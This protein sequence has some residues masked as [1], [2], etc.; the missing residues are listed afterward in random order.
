VLKALIDPAPIIVGFRLGALVS[1]LS[2]YSPI[3][4]SYPVSRSGATRAGDM[5]AFR[6]GETEEGDREMVIPLD[7]PSRGGARLAARERNPPLS[8]LAARMVPNRVGTSPSLGPVAVIASGFD[9]ETIPLFGLTSLPMTQ[10]VPRELPLVSE[11]PLSLM[12]KAGG[13]PSMLVAGR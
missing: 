4:S 1:P 7:G 8:A 9:V 13:G 10:G 3:M 6:L 12:V 11:T 5:L 2:P